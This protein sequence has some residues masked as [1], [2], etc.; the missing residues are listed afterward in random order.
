MKITNYNNLT[1]KQK[2]ILENIFFSSS[3]RKVF[4]TDIE[5]REFY[6]K[7]LGYYLENDHCFH[8]IALDKE[9]N[10]LGYICGMSDTLY[11]EDIFKIQPHLAQFETYISKYPA[12]LH[13]NLA[14]HTRGQGVGAFLVQYAIE[15][16]EASGIHI[17]TGIGSRN[18]TFYKR[19]G[20]DSI[21]ECSES[22]LCFMG[23]PL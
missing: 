23:K 2:E 11:D 1:P 19:I 9:N 10:V 6:Y 15:R 20:F 3:V 12:H 8:F 5:K 14:A 7:Y 18:R 13:I 16:L 22:G 21:V 17:I 4:E